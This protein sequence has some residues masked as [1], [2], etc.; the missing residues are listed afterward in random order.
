MAG[1]IWFMRASFS[2]RGTVPATPQVYPSGAGRLANPVRMGT[3]KRLDRRRP[4]PT[5]SME[6]KILRAI[7]RAQE[8][9][10]QDIEA[11]TIF[12]GLLDTLLEVSD[13]QY[14]FIGE[15]RTTEDG[16][17]YLKTFAIT[18]IAW[19]EQ[20]R[21]FYDENAPAG[22]EFFNLSSLFGHVIVSERP[23]IANDPDND[24]RA[25]GVPP[26]HPA[27]DAFLGLPFRSAGEMVGMVGLA[28]RP[29]GYTEALIE[30]LAPLLGTCGNI[31]M[32]RR[33]WIERQESVASLRDEEARYRAVLESAPDPIVITTRY[34]LVTQINPAAR[35][36]WGYADE[37]IIGQPV[38]MLMAEPFRTERDRDRA[39]YIETGESDFVGSRR[40]IECQRKDGS[41]FPVELT[42]T[43]VRIKNATFIV[44]MVRDLTERKRAEARANEAYAALARSRDDLMAILD[45][46]Q[47]G[48]IMLDADG[49]VAFVSESCRF[50]DGFDDPDLVGRP[51]A[52]VCP[53]NVGAAR[54]LAEAMRASPEE[55]RRV[56]VTWATPAG[57]RWW[58]E[59]DVQDDP[60]NT[61]GAILYLYD[62]SEIYTLRGELDRARYGEIIGQSR[63]MHELYRLI[64]TVAQGE[65]T[66]LIEGETGVGKE[67]VAHSIHSASPRREG[68]FIAVNCAGLS[69]SLI[70]SQLFGHR[71]GA[72]TGAVSDQEGFFEAAAGG[73]LFLDEIGDLPLPMQTSLLRALQEKE[74]IRLG[75]SRPR[76]IDVRV[77]A[78]T[79]R[80]LAAEVRAGRFREDLFYRLRVARL[81]VP[82]LR[83][84]LDDVPLLIAS[85]LDGDLPLK[86]DAEVMDLMQ[87]Y[88]WPGNVRELRNTAEYMTIHCRGDVVHK[89]H[90]P[91]EI[92]GAVA[93][94]AT[95]E[96][97]AG[98]GDDAERARI[99][100]ALTRAGGNR[101]RAA[102]LLGMSRATLYRRLDR[103]GIAD[104]H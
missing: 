30:Q 9:T 26:G 37:E 8:L 52:D 81:R 67:L 33:A 65:W 82:P 49:Q 58:F 1:S 88:D 64:D 53:F 97:V 40:E 55:R 66:V 60:R 104:R 12:D 86:L 100:D 78:A 18:D 35:A 102:R 13:S 95:A 93:D 70:A 46:L 2:L 23:V 29:G 80:D 77:F 56:S 62:R 32:A 96:I 87:A 20:T 15:T 92:R 68:P 103:L 38:S 5:M 73:T 24:P 31:V 36:A 48:T 21:A 101:T 44:G 91:P 59:I 69:E 41:R 79:N 85:F 47:V 74:I 16:R 17:R 42:V 14:G 10:L 28:N 54:R 89:S 57:Q 43:D 99:L 63:A 22:M 45:Q 51:W 3:M 7:S 75:E 19:D 76:K 83:E 71:R 61:G 4:A 27:L 6:L 84:R 90:L 72:F 39:R 94:R 25:C 98:A 11:R 34:G 50:I